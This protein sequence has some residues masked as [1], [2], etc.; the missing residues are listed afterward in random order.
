MKPAAP[1]IHRAAFGMHLFEASPEV[2]NQ[3]AGTMSDYIRGRFLSV[4]GQI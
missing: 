4:H 2:V 3:R 1:G